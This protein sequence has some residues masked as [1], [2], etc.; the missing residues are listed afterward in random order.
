MDESDCEKLFDAMV[1]SIVTSKKVTIKTDLMFNPKN[2]KQVTNLLN[3]I[4]KNG[5][6]FEFE[7]YTDP[8][9]MFITEVQTSNNNIK[10]KF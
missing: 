2:C 7:E 3:S 4:K 9:E 5:Y 10:I 6:G 8:S 1:K